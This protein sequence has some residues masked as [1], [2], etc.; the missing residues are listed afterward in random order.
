LSSVLSSSSCENGEVKELERKDALLRMSMADKKDSDKYV[1]KLELEIRETS[2]HNREL[3]ARFEAQKDKLAESSKLNVKLVTQVVE[4][5]ESITS[6]SGENTKV[7]EENEELAAQ[8]TQ[9]GDIL[10]ENRYNSSTKQSMDRKYTAASIDNVSI[11]DISMDDPQGA[12]NYGGHLYLISELLYLKFN[13][14]YPADLSSK[15]LL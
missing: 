3:K 13:D 1:K 10:R 11:N 14:P 2:E 7:K 6:L 15:L 9:L 8:V 5:Q 4:Y 12:C